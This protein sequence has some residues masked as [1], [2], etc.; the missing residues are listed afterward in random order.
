[1]K[2]PR[3]LS[4]LRTTVEETPNDRIEVDVCPT[5][6]G[7][8]FD[9]FELEAMLQL[10]N[11]GAFG[12]DS[13]LLDGERPSLRCPRNPDAQMIERRLATDRT[14]RPL[15][16]DQCPTCQGVWLDGG[17]LEQLAEKLRA[18]ELQPFINVDPQ[19][20]NLGA[21]LWLF[22]FFTGLPVEQWNPRTRRPLVLPLLVA[23]CV[24]VFLLQQNDPD[25]LMRYALVPARFLDG[26][27]WMLLSHMF[28]HGG[29]LHIAGNLYFLW[30]LG[31]N[32]EASLGRLRFLLL[33]VASGIGAAL[34]QVAS[35]PRS[36]VPMLGASGAIAGVMAA[37]AVLFPRARL[38]SL[39]F[40]WRVR[41]PARVYL[42]IWFGFQ[43]VYALV[44]EGGVA[45]WAHIGG[46][47]VGLVAAWPQRPRARA[48]GAPH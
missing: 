47:A 41:W 44:G 21:G 32:V 39:I 8:W 22:M 3:C 13:P 24:A 38:I 7:I 12:V 40:F 9:R 33:Y 43:I 2:C 1:M 42:G 16:I 18:D 25:E 17:E 26:S 19:R 14:P 11:V 46:F 30:I 6:R 20:T 37:Y 29:L 28:M 45:W 48:V 5:C 23:A 31:D 10:P 35:D 27:W 4:E 34:M 15:L 36:T